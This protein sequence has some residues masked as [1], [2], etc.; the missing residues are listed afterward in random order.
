MDTAIAS[1][2]A[3]KAAWEALLNQQLQKVVKE[4]QPDRIA[5]IKRTTM[6]LPLVVATERLA[7]PRRDRSGITR[8]TRAGANRLPGS[9][10]PQAGQ[11]G[12]NV[13]DDRRLPSRC[14]HRHTHNA[15]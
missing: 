3:S 6:D 7:T 2:D 5:E 13:L 8:T 15:R 12:S 1:E 4:D 11:P 10:C 9:R 14:G